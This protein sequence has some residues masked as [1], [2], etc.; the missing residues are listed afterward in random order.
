MEDA[1]LGIIRGWIEHPGA[2]PGKLVKRNQRD[3]NC[4]TNLVPYW[5]TN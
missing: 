5:N 2:V 1:E 3:C 4:L